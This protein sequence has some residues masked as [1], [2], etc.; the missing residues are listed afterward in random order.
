MPQMKNLKVFMNSMEDGEEIQVLDPGI[1]STV[2]TFTFLGET[3]CKLLTCY[4]F[5]HSISTN[6]IWT[7]CVLHL[8]NLQN[9]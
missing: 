2:N 1:L 5:C 9:K 8:R 6:N 3:Y 4:I 7:I